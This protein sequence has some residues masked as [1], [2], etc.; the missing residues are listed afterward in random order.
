MLR[1][2]LVDVPR[3]APTVK[4]FRDERIKQLLARILYIWAMRHPASSYVQ[5]I[6]DLAMPLIVSY[7]T[8]TQMMSTASDDAGNETDNIDYDAVLDGTIME[9]VTD[10]QLQEVSALCKGGVYLLLRNTEP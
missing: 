9:T 10:D 4:L 8:V 5:G 7:L 2:V 3:T 1:Q 6:N